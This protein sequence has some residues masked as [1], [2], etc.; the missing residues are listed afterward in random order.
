MAAATPLTPTAT[1]RTFKL[2]EDEDGEPGVTREELSQAKQAVWA[3]NGF[4]LIGTSN[5]NVLFLGKTR[6]G[7]STAISVMKDP[8]HAPENFTIFSETYDAKFQSFSIQDKSQGEVQKYTLQIIDTPGLFEVV[9]LGEQTEARTNEMIINTISKCLENE[10]TKLN[11][12]VMFASIDAGVSNDD[13]E[14]IRIFARLFRRSHPRATPV[15]H[16]TKTT[17]TTA[18][19][20]PPPTTAAPLPPIEEVERDQGPLR[21]ALCITRADSHDDRWQ[22]EIRTQLMKHPSLASIIEEAK[23][24]IIFMGCV[25]PQRYFNMQH[26]MN[27]YKRVYRMRKQMLQ[28]IFDSEKQ[29]KLLELDLMNSKN[30]QV[31]RAIDLLAENF[32]YFQKVT[33]WEVQAVQSRIDVHK[34]TALS[35]SR[36]GQAYTQVSSIA[37]KFHA[38]ITEARDFYS[39]AHVPQKLRD[40]LVWP[41]K[42]GVQE[43]S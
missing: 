26:L 34:S 20:P 2:D 21:L 6:S 41:L 5:R 42:I 22:E 36:Q 30:E 35:L 15:A 1:L 19:T 37:L 23:I 33:D 11:C 3:Q 39:C 31:E 40:E 28:F 18:G 7:K 27:A 43:H 12:V 9:E 16:P 29:Q 4:E 32:R 10:I 17:T 25:E 14:A 38:L 8:C 13:V 24:E